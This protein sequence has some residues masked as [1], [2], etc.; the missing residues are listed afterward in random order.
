MSLSNKI[1]PN[2]RSITDI[3]FFLLIAV[4]YFDNSYKKGPSKND[5]KCNVMSSL[6]YLDAY[7]DS[8]IARLNIL[9]SFFF[10]SIS[11]LGTKG[12]S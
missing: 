2:Y 11:V 8:L 6:F 9:L 12:S 10:V 3:T 7:T 5:R 1:D 4:V